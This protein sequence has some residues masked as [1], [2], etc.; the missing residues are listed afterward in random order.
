MIARRLFDVISLQHLQAFEIYVGSFADATDFIFKP[1]CF[2]EAAQTHYAL[3]AV[4]Y[5]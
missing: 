1:V 2:E 4:F 3:D 5:Y